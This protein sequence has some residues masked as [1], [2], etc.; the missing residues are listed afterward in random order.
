MNEAFRRLA[1][2]VPVPAGQ[3]AGELARPRALRAWVRAL[4]MANLPVAGARVLEGLQAL[5]ATPLARG[6]RLDVLD[7]L[8]PSLL[9]LAQGMERQV[10]GA[11]F[12]LSVAKQRLGE[13]A[14]ACRRALAAAYRQALVDQ[15]H[16]D[17]SLPLLG[18]R[19]AAGAATLALRHGSAALVQAAQLYLEPRPGEWRALHDTWLLADTLGIGGRECRAD[20]PGAPT[21]ARQAWLQAALFALANP[22]GWSQ[23]EQREVHELCAVLALR[24]G[25]RRP[26]QPGDIPV[27]GG[28]DRGPGY[29]AEETP[30]GAG[31]SIG[32]DLRPVLR[33]L[34]ELVD[35][36][37]EGAPRIAVRRPEAPS[38]EL[39]PG[40]L[41][42]LRRVFAARD[43]RVAGRLGG[44]QAMTSVIGMNALHAQLAGAGF[45][46]FLLQVQ[47][48]AI[49]LQGNEGLPAW[50]TAGSAGSHAPI[51]VQVLDHSPGGYRLLWNGDAGV[52]VRARV[53]E[54]V[55]LALAG[56]GAAARHWLVATIRW[57][58][59]DA[60]QRVHAGLELL[61]HRTLP[62]ST[63]TAQGAV[64]RALWLQ[65][66]LHASDTAPRLLVSGLGAAVLE[67]EARVAAARSGVPHPARRLAGEAHLEAAR[68]GWQRYVLRTS[69]ATDQEGEAA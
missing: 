61:G 17:G 16:R 64:Q 40:L 22:Y 51:P 53:G 3:A 15:C 19:N 47:G 45:E 30:A 59:V 1:A 6:R 68:A 38:L 32:L 69:T 67:L 62:A 56:E 43:G 37:V 18:G 54:L 28:R 57:L 52:A 65:P 5:A 34:D 41:R 33:L 10:V 12:P 50:S 7:V 66:P 60:A 25:L 9:E 21:T 39:E 27:D 11:S 2:D 55:G 58:R 48:Q 13:L 35:G 31:D 36:A 8:A 23:R 24:A 20:R 4:P 29:V 63:R 49:Q 46:D 42:R 44:G 14:L 26:S